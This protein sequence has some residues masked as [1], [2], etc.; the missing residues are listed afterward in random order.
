MPL[1]MFQL[2]MDRNYPEQSYTKMGLS[3]DETYLI[4]KPAVGK[5][6]S[7]LLMYA[8]RRLVLPLPM[9]PMTAAVSET[10]MVCGW[11]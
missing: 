5:M 7:C 6:S 2:G 10:Y 3:P 11:G 4:S 1:N 9:G 8:L